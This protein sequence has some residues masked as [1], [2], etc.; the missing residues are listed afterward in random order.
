MSIKIMTTSPE[1]DIEVDLG[2][3]EGMVIWQ[4]NDLV[5]VDKDLLKLFIAAVNAVGYDILGE[6]VDE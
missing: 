6:E 2:A 4:G 1:M 5:Y 3:G